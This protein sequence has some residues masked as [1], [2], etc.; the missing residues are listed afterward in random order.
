MAHEKPHFSLLFR[1]LT[2]ARQCAFMTGCLRSCCSKNLFPLFLYRKQVSIDS[3]TYFGCINQRKCLNILGFMEYIEWRHLACFF[4]MK[5]RRNETPFFQNDVGQIN[6]SRAF[7]FTMKFHSL[8]L[9]FL[10]QPAHMTH[11]KI[12]RYR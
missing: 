9:P 6:L 11:L 2:Q 3:R 8:L 10:V 4:A 7:T 5:F 1:E 12:S